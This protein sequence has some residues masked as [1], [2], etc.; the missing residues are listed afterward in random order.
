MQREKEELERSV[1]IYNK[2]KNLVLIARDE[3][4]FKILKENFINEIYMLPDVVLSLN[5]VDVKKNAREL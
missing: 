4:S 5:A 3:E 1:C 2:N